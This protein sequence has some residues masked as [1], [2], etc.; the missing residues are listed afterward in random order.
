MARLQTALKPQLS[1]YIPISHAPTTYRYCCTSTYAT[2]SIMCTY[3]STYRCH[4]YALPPAFISLS[5][6]PFDITTYRPIPLL[7]I[8][9]SYTLLLREGDGMS[10]VADGAEQWQRGARFLFGQERSIRP[11]AREASGGNCERAR[12]GKPIRLDCQ[13]NAD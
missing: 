13:V 11:P 4:S 5:R 3:S 1:P 8:S 9:Y 7:S 6:C 2:R 12:L 10:S